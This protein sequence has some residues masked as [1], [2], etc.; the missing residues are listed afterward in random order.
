MNTRQ[1]IQNLELLSCELDKF[2]NKA[3]NY[4]SQWAHYLEQMSF[5]M[6]R[7]ATDIRDIECLFVLSNSK[8]TE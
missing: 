8:T 1:A 7:L 4:N 6:V 5:E 3:E 2:A